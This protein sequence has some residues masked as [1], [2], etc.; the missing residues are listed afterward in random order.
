[1]SAPPVRD[2][3]TDAPATC[4]VNDDLGAVAQAMATH[5]CGAIPVVDEAP[6]RKPRGIVTDRDIVMRTV[7]EA[8]DPLK[9]KAADVMTNGAFAVAADDPAEACLEVM[10]DYR[11]RRVVVVDETG[12][13]CGIVSLADVARHLG[14]TP[15]GEVL[16]HIANAEASTSVPAA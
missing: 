5:D 9:M 13:C 8:I 14:A 4:S 10:R 11:V 12:A 16:E 7:A 1:M 6:P 15:A 2:I 3:M